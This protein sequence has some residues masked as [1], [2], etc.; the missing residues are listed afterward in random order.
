MSYCFDTS[1]LSALFRNYYRGVFKT[2]WKDFE[3]LVE[4]GNILST[5]EVS[6]EI[7]GSNIESLRD[8]AKA[9]QA[10]F[11]TPTADEGKFVAGIFAVRHFQNNIEGKKLLNGGFVA[12]PFVVAR[13]ALNGATVVTMETLKPNAA[14]IPNICE[15]FKI[16]HL[17]LEKFMEEE[18]WEF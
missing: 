12:D 11:A 13:A 9:N 4:E 3:E 14:D 7:E 18:G 2:L 15:H 16:K 6:R 10:I 1:P 5:R 8:W 17:S